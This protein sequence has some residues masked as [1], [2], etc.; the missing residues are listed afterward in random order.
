M[1][2]VASPA[3]QEIIWV[4]PWNLD[5]RHWLG[6]MGLPPLAGENQPKEVI[7]HLS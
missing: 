2:I 7:Q 1:V 4:N 3:A 5:E 6:P